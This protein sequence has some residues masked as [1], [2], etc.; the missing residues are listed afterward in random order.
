MNSSQL[1]RVISRSLA[2]QLHKISKVSGVPIQQR[3]APSKGEL[4]RKTHLPLEVLFALVPLE[5]PSRTRLGK[6]LFDMI[7]PHMD[8]HRRYNMQE[9]KLGRTLAN[10]LNVQVGRHP[11]GA[12]KEGE[13]LNRWDDASFW[14]MDS[15]QFKNW[16]GSM[17]QVVQMLQTA[18]KDDPVSSTPPASPSFHPRRAYPRALLVAFLQERK[19]ML[20]VTQVDYLLNKLA[21][22]ST[23]SSQH[24]R[25][26]SSLS[27]RR[28]V[29]SCFPRL[30]FLLLPY[31]SPSRVR[32]TL[33]HLYP[34]L[35]AQLPLTSRLQSPH[36]T[37]SSRHHPVPSSSPRHP[38]RDLASLL[39]PSE[40]L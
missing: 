24:V 17:G 27:S 34:H 3:K 11:S 22:H 32:S 9:G 4:K 31:R 7:F 33:Q 5:S 2:K 25:G 40:H 16:S 37:S 20:T 6:A 18:R 12:W 10:V 8:I 26:A 38:R 1:T 35:H 28:V 19:S 23:W 15:S 21:S 36:P 39:R 30:A 14:A 13:A 29:V